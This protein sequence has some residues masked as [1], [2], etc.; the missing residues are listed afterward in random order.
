VGAITEGQKGETIVIPRV[1]A[2]DVLQGKAVTLTGYIQTPSGTHE[3]DPTVD[4]VFALTEYGVYNVFYEANDYY[5]NLGTYEYTIWCRDTIA[6]EITL[7][8]NV[9]TEYKVGEKVTFEPVQATDNVAVVRTY[10]LVKNPENRTVL[11]DGTYTFTQKGRYEIVYYA[12]DAVG[13]ATQKRIVVEV[14]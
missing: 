1:V 12:Q 11:T 6:P 13:N 2:Y 10:I 4:T 7:P 14:K 9:K 5:G 8:T 3:I